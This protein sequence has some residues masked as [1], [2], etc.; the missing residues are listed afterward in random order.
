MRDTGES[1]QDQVLRSMEI[2]EIEEDFNVSPIIMDKI[3]QVHHFKTPKRKFKGRRPVFITIISAVLLLSSLTAYASSQ[4]IHIRNKEGKIVISTKEQQY[5]Q[6]GEYFAQLLNKYLDELKKKLDP[7]ELA[8]YYIKDEQINEADKWNPLRY[9]YRPILHRNYDDLA[10]EMKET[11]APFI[12]EPT[13]VPEGYIFESGNIST[14]FDYFANTP[15]YQNILDELKG[16]AETSQEDK[17]LFYKIVPWSKAVSTIIKYQKGEHELTIIAFAKSSDSPA[18]I[19]TNNAEKLIVGGTEMLFYTNSTG[20]KT[21][22]VGHRL[23]WLDENKHALFMILDDPKDPLSR[24]IFAK[25]AEGMI[26]Q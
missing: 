4:W 8:V 13:F 21:Q 25:I 22:Q 18:Q 2:R 5:N 10:K 11:D 26:Y 17:A 7:G 14:Q 12:Q 15:E 24:D 3:H 1:D 23:T 9:Y 19:Y 16:M 20:S 6:F